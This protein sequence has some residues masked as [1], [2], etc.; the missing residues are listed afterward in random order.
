[1]LRWSELMYIH[2]MYIK[3][4]H[5]KELLGNETLQ[6]STDCNSPLLSAYVSPIIQ[7]P[8]ASCS[9]GLKLQSYPAY[10]GIATSAI[11]E[12][13]SRHTQDWAFTLSFSNCNMDAETF[14]PRTFVSSSHPSHLQHLPIEKH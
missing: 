7:H 12:I 1:M 5:T 4:T 9:M 3:H 6:S 13:L 14:L 8:P 11:M 2:G 10:L